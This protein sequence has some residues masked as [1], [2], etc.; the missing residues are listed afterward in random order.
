MD[1][2][3]LSVGPAKY[4]VSKDYHSFRCLSRE[5][6]RRNRYGFRPIRPL[7]ISDQYRR[8]A[9][10]AEGQFHPDGAVAIA[11]HAKATKI[12]VVRTY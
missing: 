3:L 7:R 12:G 10:I 4:I 1:D 5:Q 8:S 9:R 11:A 6:V 2:G